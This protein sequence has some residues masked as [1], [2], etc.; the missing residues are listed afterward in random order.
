MSIVFESSQHPPRSR[1]S[2][3][4]ENPIETLGKT[5]FPAPRDMVAEGWKFHQIGGGHFMAA[6]RVPETSKENNEWL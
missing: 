4:S 3:Q 2:L 1:P 5:I 6:Q